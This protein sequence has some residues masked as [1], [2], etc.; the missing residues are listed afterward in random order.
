MRLFSSRTVPIDIALR[1][2]AII[3]VVFN[4]AG[5]QAGR[6]FELGGG[7]GIL[8]LLNGYSLARFAFSADTA[9]AVRQRLWQFA[10]NL[11]LPCLAIVLISFAAK[12]AF[13]WSE[14]FFVSNWF[15]YDHISILYTWYP[16][17]FLQVLAILFLLFC[18][19]GFAPLFFRNRFAVTLALLALS[20]AT[21][22]ISLR[23]FYNPALGHRLPHF[24]IWQM[25]AGSALYFLLQHPDTRKVWCRLLAMA[26]LGTI[27]YFNWEPDDGILRLATFLFGL[28]ALLFV[29]RLVL[30]QPLA[31]AVFIVS[32]AAFVIFLLHAFTLGIFGVAVPAYGDHF[33]VTL[34]TLAFLFTMLVATGYWL[35][36]TAF[37]TTMRRRLAAGQA[38]G[39]ATVGV[40][41]TA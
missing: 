39:M 7:I 24:L 20:T 35:A 12:G 10:I 30:W 1:A 8:L 27:M 15:R 3:M 21:L 41:R 18:I 16:Q 28:A 6:P 2:L 19:P 5:A 26:V 23:Y 4:H 14:L 9:P 17:V 37:A 31:R 22:F 25:L 34:T 11:L 38:S 29:D 33:N 36:W 32:Q 13:S 40:P